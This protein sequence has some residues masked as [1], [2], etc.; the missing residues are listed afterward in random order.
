MTPS[1]S[2]KIQLSVSVYSYTAD[3]LVTMSL[4]DCLADIADMG[5]TG[6]EILADTHIP[7]YP[8]PSETW[9]DA[10]HQLLQKYR[11]TATSVSTWIDSRMFKNRS[12]TVDEGLAIL[13]RDIKL[14]HR[15][16]FTII[17]PKL[18]VITLDLL[19]DPTWRD[20]IRRA[21]PYAQEYNVRMAPE[22]HAPTPLR[23]KIVEDYV[24]LAKETGTKYFGLLVDT[25][26]FQNQVRAGDHSDSKH[27]FG[28]LDP[29]AAAEV[30]RVMTEPLCVDPEQLV[31]VMPWLFHVHAK[32][33]DMTDELTD[34]H[35]PWDKVVAALVKGGYSGWISSEYEGRR[36]LFRAADILRRQHVMLRTL[37]AQHGVSLA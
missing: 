4:E 33:W 15:L 14:A 37:F 30:G 2:N 20:I 1:P 12:L 34:P 5:A 25:G 26:V 16:G 3:F 9:I 27:F 32:F 17:R 23:S 11:L 36:D 22:I 13:V 24:A 28:S 35:I 21:L 31:D 19:P 6:V 29:A 7:G 8:N 10:W 18:G